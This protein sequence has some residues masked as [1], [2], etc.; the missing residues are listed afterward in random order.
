MHL[1]YW[2]VH[3]PYRVPAAYGEPFADTPLPEWLSAEV[4]AEHN[5]KTGPHSSLDIYMYHDR[6]DP[7]YPR[8]P[9]KLT[10]QASLRRMIDGYDTAIRYVDDQLEIIL[11]A[12]SSRGV[13]DDTAI[14]ISADHG[15]NMGELGIYGEHATAD[16]GTIHRGESGDP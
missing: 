4:L 1:N 2:D 12:L 7:Q 13:L 11:T 16:Q 9:G 14:I 6:E 5:K 8:H 15:E 3:T 10:D